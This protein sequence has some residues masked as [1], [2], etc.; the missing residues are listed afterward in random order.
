MRHAPLVRRSAGASTILDTPGSNPV[1]RPLPG[2]VLPFF[3]GGTQ[4]VQVL[5]TAAWGTTAV[6]VR[7]HDAVGADPHPAVASARPGGTQFEL[8]RSGVVLTSRVT[9]D[10]VTALGYILYTWGEVIG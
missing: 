9:H 2:T 1:Q 10:E 7:G 5:L 4:A 3:L 6:T 8:T